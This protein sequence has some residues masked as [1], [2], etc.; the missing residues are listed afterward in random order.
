MKE[1]ELRKMEELKVVKTDK[2]ALP[3]LEVLMIGPSPL[4][5]DAFFEIQHLKNLKSFHILD[6]PREFVLGMHPNGGRN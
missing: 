4:L 1:L 6:M 5:E 2:R 3:L